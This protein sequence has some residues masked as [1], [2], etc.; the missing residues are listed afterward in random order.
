MA[1][2]AD[3][4]PEEW[5]T[6]A[7]AAPMAALAITCASP[8]GPLG[9]MKEMFSMGM[10]MAE[11][12]HKG[13][14]NPLIASLIADLKARATRLEPPPAIKDAE[15]GKQA[16]LAQLKTVAELL[17]RKAASDAEEFKRW[18]Q[19]VAQR[20]AEAANEGGFFG[21]GGE[22]V[23]ESEKQTLN[24]IAFVLGLPRS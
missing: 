12:I 7:A 4:T 19:S 13:S 11:I 22:R 15:Q 8:N 9:V 16:A 3:F 18:L 24:Q 20:V 10:A 23:S 2:K 14:S 21:F 17:D 6:I 1:T 5:K